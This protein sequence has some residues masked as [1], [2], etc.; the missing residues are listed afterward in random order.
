MP[1]HPKRK[2]HLNNIKENVLKSAA[3]EGLGTI[4][5]RNRRKY[6]KIWKD[7]IKQFIETKKKSYKIAEF[8]ET[9]RKTGMLKKHR[10]GQKRRKKM[11]KTFLGQICY[12]FRIG[13][14]QEPTQGV[15][16][17]KTN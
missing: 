7:Q 15:Q 17:F 5:R 16:N 13:N 9:R 2:L 1:V 12:K 10:T 4:K 6:L 11:T 8:K 3:N 14:I